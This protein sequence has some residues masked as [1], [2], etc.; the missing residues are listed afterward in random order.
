MYDLDGR[1]ERRRQG[2]LSLQQSSIERKRER[3]WGRDRFTFRSMDFC[4]R[5]TARTVNVSQIRPARSVD[6]ETEYVI[7][8]GVPLL[9]LRADARKLMK[10]VWVMMG[11]RQR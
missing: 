7:T 8:P 5:V 11:T 1:G 10:P 9:S 6:G 4:Q 3:G 2:K